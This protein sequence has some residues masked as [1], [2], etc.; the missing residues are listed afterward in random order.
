MKSESFYSEDV[1]RALDKIEEY[2][3]TP[4]KAELQYIK[5]RIKGKPT[6]GTLEFLM[7]REEYF[8]NKMSN[9][10]CSDSDSQAATDKQYVSTALMYAIKKG[11]K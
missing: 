3:E 5:A 2:G 9:I 1:Q 6:E 11:K 10:Y 8:E 4:E 7:D